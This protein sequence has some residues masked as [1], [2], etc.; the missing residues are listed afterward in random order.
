MMTWTNQVPDKPGW[1]WLLNPSEESGLPA[2]VQIY[3]DW[4]TGRSVAIIPA[5]HPKASVRV[6]DLRNFDAMWVGPIELPA[7]LSDAA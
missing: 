1:Y 7:V 3:F 6:Q 4:E 2:V 5:S